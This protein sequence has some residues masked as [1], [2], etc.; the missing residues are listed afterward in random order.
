MTDQART[1]LRHALALNEDEPRSSCA[2][3]RGRGLGV[4][5]PAG[6]RSDHR[7]VSRSARFEADAAA[8]LENAAARYEQRR[9]GLGL[10]FIDAVDR[11]V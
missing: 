3:R 6:C 4:L 9:P 10:S 11:A 1:V 2:E 8:E 7:D 5:A